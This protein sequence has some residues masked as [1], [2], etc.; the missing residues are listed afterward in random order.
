MVGYNSTL[1]PSD[2]K[3]HE[4]K[5]RVKRSGV[6]VRARKGYWALTADE[7]ARA[8]APPKPG[9][10]PGV[11]KALAAVESPSRAEVVRTWVGMGMAPEGRTRVTL[12]WEPVSGVPGE[13]RT[14]PAR[15]SVIAA[16]GSG[17]SYFRG[18]V[19]DESDT[20]T[21]IGAAD[22]GG[23]VV[24][25]ADPGTLQM[26][27]AV[28]DAGGRVL[29]S[30]LLD[31]QVPDFT[32]PDVALSTLAVHRV[33]TALELRALNADP[34]PVPVAARE[35]RRTERLIVRF[36]AMAP[37]ETT[38]T[39]E[40]RLLNRAGQSMATLPV[41]AVPNAEGTSQIDLPLSGLPPGEYVLEIRAVAGEAETKQLLGFRVVG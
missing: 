27:L 11:S 40:A 14:E 37:G 7:T 32:A 29:D 12:V 20:T 25:D 8:L 30:D 26:R 15:L 39:R 36:Q 3:F 10:D 35:F 24:F 9:P 18:K 28:E 19:P 17:S 5:V 33:R 38:P 6:Q 1:A 23:R 2:G 21:S 16:G 4:I 41:Q 22:R 13:R 31:L 34:A